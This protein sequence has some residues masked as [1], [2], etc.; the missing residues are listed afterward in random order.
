MSH[1][2]CAQWISGKRHATRNLIL[3][4]SLA[5]DFVQVT[6]LQGRR[7]MKETA[8]DVSLRDTNCHF[9]TYLSG[10]EKPGL[11]RFGFWRAKFPIQCG[12]LDRERQMPT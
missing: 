7:A 11:G 1:Y 6:D 3:A 12:V 5:A 10:P 2:A 4:H 8:N 9:E